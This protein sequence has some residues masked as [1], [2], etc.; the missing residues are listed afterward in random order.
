MD[1]N[2][3]PVFQAVVEQGQLSRAAEQLGMSQ[4]AVSAAL[5]RLHLTVGEPLF[6]RTR[7]GLQ[8][9]ARAR[10]MYND[11]SGALETMVGTLSPGSGFD[12]GTSERPFRMVAMD[13]FDTL[14]LGPLFQTLREHGPGLNVQMVA[15][16]EGWQQ[17][18]L[19][20]K[21]D[22][23]LDTEMTE[24]PRLSARVV[25]ETTLAVIAA[26]DHPQIRGELSL[27]QFLEAE[28]VVLPPRERAM[29]PLD[30]LLG[31]P[32]WRRKIG[33][34]VNQYSNLLSVARQSHLIATVPRELALYG[35][36]HGELQVLPFPIPAGPVPVYM[37]WSR[38]LEKD[39]GHRWFRERVAEQ[40]ERK[41]PG[42]GST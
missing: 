8:P 41:E 31:R 16:R 32:G 30:R 37:L 19:E 9:T 38:S 15:Q 36:R 14:L 24:N 12:P 21:A 22:L 42:Q 35:A 39:L 2:L 6:I 29:L 18:L 13:V 23:A 4:P 17:A 1:L 34:Q 25:N 7:G 20:G 10:A 28:H 40:F 27:A 3:L 11:L 5:K 26:R 33:V